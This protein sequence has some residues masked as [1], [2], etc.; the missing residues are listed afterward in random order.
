MVIPMR[1]EGFL[2]FRLSS[3][4][5]L[6]ILGAWIFG[7]WAHTPARAEYSED[8]QDEPADRPDGIHILDGSYVLDMG[9]FHVNITNHGLIGS[10]YT[11]GLPYSQSPS[12]EWPGG[13]GNE[14]LWG[15]GLWVGALVHGE[16]GVT[17]GQPEREL[18]PDNHLID[19]I[20]EARAARIVRPWPS[21]VET[22]R[23]LP[24]ARADDDGDNAYDE[25]ILNGRDDDGDGKVDE[26]FGQIG[27]Q[28]FT[29]TMHDNI[30][31]VRELYP[32]HLPLGITVVQNA[33][34]WANEEYEDIVA[35]EFE[36][37]N[38]GYQT[39]QDVYLGF[40][41]DCDIQRRGD[42]NSEPDDLA[43]MWSG[44]I[45]G[46]D[47]VFH[48]VE[49]AWMRD[50]DPNNPLPG[51]I[52]TVLLDHDTD[53]SELRAPRKVSVR[54]YQIFATNARV[55][56]DGEP[57]S[58]QDRYYL[59]SRQQHDPDQRLDQAGDLKFMISSGPFGHVPPGRK[60][61]YRLAMVMGRDKKEMLENAVKA[62][63]IAK[64]RYFDLDKNWATGIGGLETKV[65][66]GDLPRYHGGG[67]PLFNYRYLFMDESCT[68]SNPIFGVELIN[69]DAMFADVDGRTCIY[70]NADNCEEC[71]RAM[72]QECTEENGLY[73]KFLSWYSQRYSPQY[74]TG[75]RG[76]EERVPWISPGEVPPMPPNMR[77]VPGHNQVEIFWDDVSE[78]DPD[79]LRNVIDFESYRIWRV[80]NFTR[81]AGTDPEAGPTSDQWA[82]IEEFDIANFTLPGATDSPNRLPLGRNTGLEPAAYV[83]VSLGDPTFE[84]LAEVMQDF[85]DDDPTGQYVTMPPLR[86]SSG[87]VIPGREAFIPWETWPSVLDTFFAVTPREESSGVVGKRATSYYHYLDKE[88]HDGFR[89]FISVV[90]TDHHLVWDDDNETWLPAGYGIQ[91]EPGNNY[92]VTIPAPT[93]Q[94]AEMREKM[95]ANIY[96]FPN[97]A[98]REALAEFQKQPASAN[99]PTGERIMFT[100]LPA[101]RNTIRIFT[102]SGDLVETVYHDGL[103]NG[104]GAYWNLVSRN[105]QEVVSGIYLYTVQSDDSRFE[106]FQGRFVIIR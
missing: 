28:M 88:V 49:V 3:F 21:D 25:D 24:D 6:L 56:Q 14:Y 65:C 61:T 1:R 80:A 102:T 84:G 106:D 13:S 42:G 22:G 68:G 35:L 34:T 43:G 52:G 101:A 20:Y 53:F 19:T 48:R 59:M 67:E 31:L 78:Y 17:T 58:D 77:L 37:T 90:A 40:Y 95:G 16:A 2:P 104:G 71:Y 39:L 99:D 5:R 70:V 87:A 44:A 94:T 82:M 83:P 7:I 45:R 26:D 62:L 66:L 85:I 38:T 12:G 30:P 36:I 51:W 72:G 57:K 33:A 89:T 105:G 63:Q 81:P 79:Y 29:A 92:Q 69:K 98:T 4:W 9:Q 73:W 103:S 74:F 93:P 50:G 86:D 75:I 97:P 46:S 55:V 23:R 76:R 60:L 91:T 8:I 64:G 96:V 15:A 27:D 41:V 47:R 54:S 10:Q 18:R 32:S 11:A 100:N